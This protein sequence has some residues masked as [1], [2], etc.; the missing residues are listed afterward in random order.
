MIIKMLALFPLPARLP[1]LV[2]SVGAII[3]MPI[4]LFAGWIAVP[5]SVVVVLLIFY[6][7][8]ISGFFGWLYGKFA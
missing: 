3:G 5:I 7:L 1:I 6:A 2:G 8:G 4:S